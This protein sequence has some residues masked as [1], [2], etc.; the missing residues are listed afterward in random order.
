[1][2]GG[3]SALLPLSPEDIHKAETRYMDLSNQG[4]AG[5]ALT[6]QMGAYIEELKAKADTA[7]GGPRSP[8]KPRQIMAEPNPLVC[9]KILGMVTNHAHHA[10]VVGTDGSEGAS[11]AMATVLG[12]MKAKDTLEVLH[13]CDTSKQ[14]P[15]LQAKYKPESI[16][17]AVESE[18]T[19]TLPKKRWKLSWIDKFNKGSTSEV[20]A[21]HVNSSAQSASAAIS[22]QAPSFYVSGFVGR[23]GP[24]EVRARR[25]S[26]AYRAHC[27]P[28]LA[29]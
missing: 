11:D 26:S 21:D 13:I 9:T 28:R 15:D 2:G 8:R 5:T 10:W 29:G 25:R 7:G 6:E 23:K 27:R 22:R 20:I 1:M 17:L 4:V 14:D 24:K 18:L 3:M 16:R 19:G 12:L